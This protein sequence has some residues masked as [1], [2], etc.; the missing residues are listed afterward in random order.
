MV[1]VF[2]AQAAHA[3]FQVGALAGAGV[4][5]DADTSS[6]APGIEGGIYAGYR[7]SLGPLH[8]QPELLGRLNTGAPAGGAA[9]GALATFGTLVNFGAYAHGGIGI[10]GYPEPTFDAGAVAEVRPPVI[11]LAVGLRIG[12]EKVNPAQDKCGN[13]AQPSDQWL[14]VAATVGLSF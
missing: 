10:V 4:P 1:L 12:W 7:A 2:L 3:G 13:C 6:T 14:M 8:L 5:L 11:P 9:L